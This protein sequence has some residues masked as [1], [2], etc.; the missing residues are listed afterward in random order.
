MVKRHFGTL[1]SVNGPK[2]M[3]KRQSMRSNDLFGQL[4]SSLCH[5]LYIKLSVLDPCFTDSLNHYSCYKNEGE[6]IYNDAITK[7]ISDGGY[8]PIILTKDEADFV[9]QQFPGEPWVGLTSNR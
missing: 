2:T 6:L 5:F 4:I 9:M 3:S 8:L 7:C 1:F